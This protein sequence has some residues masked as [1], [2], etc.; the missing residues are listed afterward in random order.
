MVEMA[1]SESDPLDLAARLRG[2]C[3]QV[4]GAPAQRRIDE[5]ETIVL[6]DEVGVDRSESGELE[7]VIVK[8][9]DTHRPNSAAVPTQRFEYQESSAGS[10]GT[11]VAGTLSCKHRSRIAFANNDAT[12]IQVSG[13]SGHS[14]VKLPGNPCPARLI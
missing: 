8:P 2:G 4:I 3:D 1:V 9:A 7:Q 10:L 13:D 5:C 11:V 12:E 6:A 14:T